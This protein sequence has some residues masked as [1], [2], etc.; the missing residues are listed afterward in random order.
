MGFY[1]NITN[2][3]RTQFQFDLV[4]P[5]RYEMERNTFTD[6]VYAG[7][8]VLVEYDKSM[9]LDSFIRVQ[10]EGNVAYYNPEGDTSKR[11][12]VTYEIVKVGEVVYT[13]TVDKTPANGLQMKDCVFYICEP[14]P[15][16][17]ATTAAIFKEASV[18]EPDLPN[19]TI[20]YNIDTKYYGSGRGYDS[21]VWQ[22]VYT[23]EKEKYVMIAEL[24]TV[25]PTFDISPDAP[26]LTP[27]V[28][29]FDTNSTDVYYKLHWQPAWGFRV[30]QGT[31]GQSDENTVWIKQVY[32]KNTDK[33]DSF[34]FDGTN[35]QPYT[36][37][38]KTEDIMIPAAVYYNRAGLDDVV[39]THVEGI[40]LVQMVPSG[41]SG[42]TYNKHDGTA[43][44]ETKPDIQEWSMIL[45]SIGNIM[46]S[47]WD[48]I[49]G[50]NADN[51]NKRYRDIAWK[52]AVAIENDSKNH[53]AQNDDV[54]GMTRDLTTIAGC[55]NSV[56]DLMGM[57]ITKQKTDDKLN[58]V[59]FMKDYIYEDN[60]KYY[61]IHKYPLYTTSTIGALGLPDP[62]DYLSDQEYNKAYEER[63]AE[64][65]VAGKTYYLIKNNA[66]NK[67]VEVLN[68]K[69]LSAYDADTLVGFQNGSFG[70][71]Y[72]E[73]PEMASNLGTIYGLILKMKNL[74][75][76]EDIHT[77]DRET[78]QGSI[79]VINDIIDLFESIVPGEFL[80]CDSNGKVN[81][82]NW[83]TA[84]AFSYKNYK[85]LNPDPVSVTAS[86]LSSKTAEDRWLKLDLDP[87]NRQISLTHE[88]TSVA[89]TTTTADKNTTT[90]TG[91]NIGTGDSIYLYTPIVDAKGHVVGHN[92]ETV[93]LPYGFKTIK[94]TNTNDTVVTAPAT[95]I[96]TN[97][98][99]AD[100]TK[101]TLTFSASNRWIKLDNNTEDTVKIGHKLSAFVT[102]TAPNTLY[103]LTQNEDHTK[104]TNAKGHL[105]YDNTFEV[106]CLQFDEAG[107]ILEARTHT[108]TL[109]ENFTS[110]V[111]TVSDDT[112]TTKTEGAAGTITADTMIDTLTLSEGNRW[113]LL[114]ADSANDK[115]TISHY[116]EPIDLSTATTDFNTATGK[117]FPI[118]E[119]TWDAAGHILSN[120]THTYTLPDSIK[121]I[122]ITNSGKSSVSVDATAA[123]GNLVA[124]T[125]VD[126]ATF[127]IGNR[128]LQ[129]VADANN[130]K[131]T[132]YHAAPGAQTNTTDTGNEE[133]N[134]GT[135][136]TIPEVKYDEAGHISGTSTHTVKLPLPSINAL[137]A[138]TSSVLTGISMNGATGAITQ[139]NAS[140]GTLAL[141]GYTA[142]SHSLA[143][144]S[145]DV[146]AT[147]SINVAFNKLQSQIYAAEQVQ[148]DDNDA[149]EAALKAEAKSRTDADTALGKRIDDEATAR[150]NADIALGKRIDDEITA[151]SNADT[152][153]G[154]RIDDEAAAR[155]TADIVLG[156]RID[157]EA[158]TRSNADTALDKRI[159]DEIT[160]RT[161]A[162][163]D[164]QAARATAITNAVNSEASTRQAADSSLSAEITALK[165]A[166]YFNA[167]SVFT[168]N[169]STDTLQNIIA[170][171]DARLLAI[172]THLGFIVEETPETP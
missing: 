128:W 23:E 14:N 98:Q 115:I 38:M 60:N 121:T 168:Y 64:V 132:L 68:V 55:I 161:K 65:L 92:I 109:P 86:S 75:E 138:T 125:L 149:M 163:G 167:A 137:T 150:S 24:N 17:S 72:I 169:N 135:T 116:V 156:K 31:S 12:K 108:V 102:G 158:T 118:H 58:D 5:N 61:R 152:A 122:A 49:Y 62:A 171:I 87:E 52:D 155:D 144:A 29:H 69:A 147:D 48:V 28:P 47:V 77:R 22:K 39:S 41:V 42:N 139:T 159:D 164:E 2:T 120:K 13:S 88:F 44:T 21:T 82:A 107:H 67:Q 4:Y 106:P 30:A 153:L 166:A 99:I 113:V 20:N 146:A 172:E 32:N 7:R 9:K 126:T 124:E 140:V 119:L 134:F 19:Y 25:V 84:Q 79:N 129:F 71:E 11:T 123:N 101:D 43:G 50:A 16:N 127:D 53:N 93:V 46:A 111:V 110:V 85:D 8:Y 73:I 148:I 114:N 35:W 83:S 131:V 26:T 154:K 74:L 160:A 145:T 157:S 27:I 59:W 6:G 112:A 105:D 141:T 34:Y 165:K 96:A 78:L 81:S 133:P 104:A 1:G 36:E 97:G 162:I 56:H 15:T 142:V 3:A 80:I 100:N 136:F 170:S 10:F 89:D 76:V 103:G 18:N 54:G 90:G 70:Y 143:N 117:T 91:M 66:A 151:R 33:N 94:A 51:G 45:P 37:D 40:D 130:D 57:I 95:T 63:L